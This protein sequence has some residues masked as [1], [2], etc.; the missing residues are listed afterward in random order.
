MKPYHAIIVDN[1]PLDRKKL[2]DFLKTETDIA[3]L[4][5]S[6][7]GA[8]AIIKILLHQPQIVFLDLSMTE[9]GSMEVLKEIWKHYKP[10]V[11]FTKE[12]KPNSFRTSLTCLTKPYRKSQLLA[13][14]DS[15]KNLIL[16]GSQPGM[17]EMISLVLGE[18]LEDIWLNGI[19]SL[20]VREKNTVHLL[21]VEDIVHFSSEENGIT[22]HTKVKSYT[23]KDNIASLE[24]RLDRSC[25]IRTSDRDIINLSFMDRLE[26]HKNG[27]YLVRLSTGQTVKW[28]KGYRDNI[29]TFLAK[30]G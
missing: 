18:P 2:A 17:E 20:L 19:Q 4:A 26:H 27:E 9:P 23:I 14:I 15:A 29:K 21:P 12:E 30:V 24:H 10:Y 5:E 28:D 13:A 1:Y 25:M 6:N 8:D 22:L 11:I 3:L 7:T 16:T